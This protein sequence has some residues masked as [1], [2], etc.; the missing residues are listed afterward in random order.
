MAL[1]YLALRFSNNLNIQHNMFILA[2]PF[3]YC[4]RNLSWN[5]KSESRIKI[6]GLGIRFGKAQKF[7]ISSTKY[8]RLETI[9]YI[10]IDILMYSF[11]LKNQHFLLPIC[12]SSTNTFFLLFVFPPFSLPNFSLLGRE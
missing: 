7:K 1:G 2:I 8:S 3:F 11:S 5:L 10:V 9:L 6:L 4:Q 12:N